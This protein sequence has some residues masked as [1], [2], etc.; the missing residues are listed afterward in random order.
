MKTR[1]RGFLFL[2]WGD[3]YLSEAAASAKQLRLYNSEPISLITDK[4]PASEIA[5]H[6]DILIF[7][8]LKGDYRD[9][10]LIRHTPFALTIFLDTYIFCC[11]P[12]AELFSVLDEFDIAVTFTEGGNHYSIPGVPSL[13]HEPSAGV[14]AW[15]QGS[16]TNN[17]FDLWDAWYTKIEELMTFWGAWDQRSL[18]AALYFSDTR[19]CPIPDRYQFYTYR[20][21]IVEGEVLAIHGRNIPRALINSVNH[22]KRLRVWL[23]RIGF[24]D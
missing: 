24:F 19:I 21:N 11:S 16:A 18:R 10:V 2:A 7:K 9:K 22:S 3:K 20:P 17:L 23:P 5:Q 1:E 6:F 12:L 8:N 13:F 15:R 4:T 14:I